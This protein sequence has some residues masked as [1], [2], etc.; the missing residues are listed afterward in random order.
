MYIDHL[1]LATKTLVEQEVSGRS[2][3]PF[4]WPFPQSGV[5]V[6]DDCRR[7]ATM[8]PYPDLRPPTL[9]PG[10]ASTAPHLPA[11]TRDRIADAIA[12]LDDSVFTTKFGMTAHDAANMVRA[13]L[14]N[15]LLARLRSDSNGPD[16]HAR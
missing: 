7:E 9:A 2:S 14:A 16:R 3:A 6:G 12:Q 13:K 5:H 4:A 15:A 1:L 10:T 11:Y 8:M